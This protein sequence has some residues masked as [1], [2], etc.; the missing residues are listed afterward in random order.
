MVLFSGRLCLRGIAGEI[1]ELTA[2]GALA[3]YSVL[4]RQALE[5]GLL[6]HA[7]RVRL[8]HGEKVYE[9]TLDADFLDVKSAKLP[10]L[11]SEEDDDRLT[12]RLWLAEQLGAILQALLESFMKLRGGRKWSKEIVPKLKAWMRGEG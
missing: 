3:A 12:E 11:M 7:A 5:R 6:L 9:V 1:T 8:T 10:E 4:V 2:R